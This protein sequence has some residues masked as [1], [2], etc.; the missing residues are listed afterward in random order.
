MI[1]NL[2][3]KSRK[4]H[5]RFWNKVPAQALL[6]LLTGFLLS[7]FFLL[8]V[9]VSQHP[10]GGWQTAFGN[11]STTT[12]LSAVLIG[13]VLCLIVLWKSATSTTRSSSA[14]NY[15]PTSNN[16]TFIKTSPE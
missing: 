16:M 14:S 8:N 11:I 13:L 2:I 4:I 3:N 1:F 10:D 15:S 9:L 7:L 6:F 5:N 12:V